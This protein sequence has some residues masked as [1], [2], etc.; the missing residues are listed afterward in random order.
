KTGREDIERMQK[1]YDEVAAELTAH[2]SQF[3]RLHARVS[4]DAHTIAT[5]D[6]ELSSARRRLARVE[7][8]V[9][10]QLFQR[11]RY[12]VFKFLGGGD[13][14]AVNVLQGSL[15]LMG[16][17]V[18]ASTTAASNGR[19]AVSRRRLGTGPIV[20]PESANPYVSLVVP[21]YS[22]A[23]LTRAALESILEC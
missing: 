11:V 18:Q 20:F 22:H 14:G 6:A 7:G 10:W 1:A 19:Q 23:D 15:R 21:L 12:R 16:R 5:L 17:G 3:E 4:Q 9:T 8:S 13:S 2:Q